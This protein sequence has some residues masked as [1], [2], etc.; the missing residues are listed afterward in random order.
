MMVQSLFLHNMQN[1]AYPNLHEYKV[2]YN[3]NINKSLD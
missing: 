1:D 2:L 3:S